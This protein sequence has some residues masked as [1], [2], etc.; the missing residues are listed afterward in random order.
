MSKKT[1]KFY[2]QPDGKIDW[3]D[4]MVELKDTFKNGTDQLYGL[5]LNPASGCAENFRLIRERPHGNSEYYQQF[6]AARML[7]LSWY[8]TKAVDFILEDLR[9]Q[10]KNWPWWYK[11]MPPTLDVMM[12]IHDARVV[13]E[14]LSY[15]GRDYVDKVLVKLTTRWPILVLKK[16]LDCEN[17]RKPSAILILKLLAAHPDW[18]EPLETSCNEVQKTTLANLLDLFLPSVDTP[19][20]KELLV[21]QVERWTTTVL[22]KLL[23]LNP[24]R[25]QPAAMFILELLAAHPDYLEQIKPAC[26]EAQL[27]TLQRL[28]ET[29]QVDEAED[30]DL[31]QILRQP[32]WRGERKLKDIP[33]MDLV[34]RHGAAVVHSKEEVQGKIISI[35]D[36]KIISLVDKEFQQELYRNKQLPEEVKQW[37]TMNKILYLLCIK[38][39]SIERVVSTGELGKEDLSKQY[40]SSS[41]RE[42]YIRLLPKPLAEQM[43]SLMTLSFFGYGWYQATTIKNLIIWLGD[44]AVVRIAALI[45]NSRLSLPLL[46]DFGNIES[47]HLAVPMATLMQKNKWAKPIARA[48]L[49]RFPATAAS[50]LI[51]AALGSNAELSSLAQR[52]LHWLQEQGVREV[53]LQEAIEYGEAADLAIQQLLA[54]SAADI[55]PAKLPAA[56][57]NIPLQILPRLLLKANGRAIPLSHVPEVLMIF[58]LC[59]PD[60]PYVGLGYL[61]ETLQADSLARFGQGLFKW[62]MQNEAPSKERW[63]FDVQGLIGNDETARLLN[64]A[65]RQWRAALNRVRAH[66]ALNMLAQIGSDVALMYLDTLSKQTRFN[67][68]HERATRLMSEVAEQRGLTQ[69]QL[70]DRTVPALGLDEQGKL[71]LDFGARQ[72]VLR[73]NETLQPLLQ[74]TNGKLIKTLPKPNA[75]DDQGCAKLATSL[76]QDVKKQAKSVAS[77]QIKRLEAAM[78]EQRHWNRDEFMTFFVH[79]PLTRNMAQAL[80]WGSFNEHN[81]LVSVFRVAEDL[82]LTDGEDDEYVLSDET[83]IGIVHPLQLSHQQ[84]QTVSQLL[85]DYQKIQPFK[86]LGREV[87]LPMAEELHSRSLSAWK[88]DRSVTSASLLGLE[89]RGWKRSV[90]EDAM[91]YEFSKSLG[92]QGTATLCVS[93]G[94]H[95]AE[96]PESSEV[97]EIEQV[98]LGDAQQTWGEISAISYSEVQR[99]LHLM[100]WFVGT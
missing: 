72:F 90:G 31:P 43:F 11:Q 44:V 2:A 63:I 10:L 51:P 86:Q 13:D 5:D 93:P 68:L 100:A 40:I 41:Y 78:C 67:D 49:L 1:D 52:T 70:A 59:K 36:D 58:L 17:N 9:V 30:A 3:A 60:Q 37:P 55:L 35:T 73:F 66:D 32:P 71:L 39:E 87:Y 79:H 4:W 57:K 98:T 97:H 88:N 76:F 6:E 21:K 16:L 34:I 24:S 99:D 12:Q 96:P 94:W 62:W 42:I 50:G 29:E 28:L 75:K 64:S 46:K 61:Q 82:T 25:N 91:I 84:L 19:E 53:I 48:W 20:I 69:D 85:M 33:K 27:K 65:L 23:S 56:P 8:Q 81:Q 18:R 89:Q 74:E 95:V 15:M 7:L 47:T 38:L 45:Q 80:I 14:L 26:N 22:P 83:P 77:M 54:T 92:S